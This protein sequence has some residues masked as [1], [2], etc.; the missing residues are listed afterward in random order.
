VSPSATGGAL[1]LGVSA[2]EFMTLSRREG[3]EDGRNRKEKTLSLARK[4][5][6]NGNAAE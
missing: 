2:G 6:F 4:T 3:D 5:S 1:S